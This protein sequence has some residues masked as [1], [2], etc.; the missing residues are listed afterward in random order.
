MHRMTVWV[1]GGMMVLALTV[2]VGISMTSAP[3]SGSSLFAQSGVASSTAMVADPKPAPQVDIEVTLDPPLSVQRNGDDAI[4][5]TVMMRTANLWPVTAQ[6]VR[7]IV[8]IPPEV[9]FVSSSIPGCTQEGDIV[10]CVF[11]TIAGNQTM[12]AALTYRLPAI[13]GSCVGQQI[14]FRAFGWNNQLDVDNG[15]NNALAT[16]TVGCP[17]T[18][19]ADLM[20]YKNGPTS[21]NRGGTVEYGIYVRNNGPATAE[22]VITTDIFPPGLTFL[23]A[24][25]D[26]RC[27]QIDNTVVCRINSLASGQNTTP[28]KIVY[29][30]AED[31]ACGPFALA[32]WV[33]G[34]LPDNDAT[35]DT[36]AHQ[37]TVNCASSSS[38]ASQGNFDVSVDLA[39]PTSINRGSTFTLIANVRNAGPYA[40]EGLE[41][42]LKNEWEDWRGLTFIPSQSD[43]RCTAVPSGELF[44]CDMTSLPVGGS[45]TLRL[46]FQSSQQLP[47]GSTRFVIDVDRTGDYDDFYLENNYAGIVV[48]VTCVSSSTPTS[49][50][51]APANS[52]DIEVLGS[53]SPVYV[54]G[55]GTAVFTF[56]ARNKGPGR[57][58]VQLDNFG[59]GGVSFDSLSD[60]RCQYVNGIVSCTLG[61]ID[62]GQEMSFSLTGRVTLPCGQSFS[63]DFS[64]KALPLDPYQ[65]NNSGGAYGSVVCGSSSAGMSNSSI[66][67]YTEWSMSSSRISSSTSSRPVAS[68]G[69]DLELTG[70]G[71]AAV[72]RGQ[73][74]THVLTMKNYGP[75]TAK[76]NAVYDPMGNGFT[77][78]PTDS[79]PRCAMEGGN[80]KCVPGDI[81]PGASETFVVSINTSA[82][83]TCNGV[84][85]INP[86]LYSYTP[87]PFSTNNR[88]RIDTKVV[89]GAVSAQSSVTIPPFSAGSSVSRQSS[90]ISMYTDW[91]MS[92][93]PVSSISSSTPSSASN[94]YDV[95]IRAVTAP[96]AVKGEPTTLDLVV[97]NAGPGTAYVMV[98]VIAPFGSI[99][100]LVPEQTDSRCARLEGSTATV[101]S[102]GYMTAGQE[103][104]ARLGMK[105]QLPCDQSIN[106]QVHSNS[107]PFDTNPQ[108]NRLL[109]P[110]KVIC[111]SSSRSSVNP[112]SVSPN[113]QV[114]MMITSNIMN[115]KV[116][117]GASIIHSFTVDNNGPDSASNVV[118]TEAIPSGFTY[119]DSESDPL[120]EQSGTSVRCPLGVVE[121]FSPVPV[122]I[123]LRPGDTYPCGI[124][125]NN[126]SVSASQQDRYA[127]SN[128][129]V[130]QTKVLCQSAARINVAV[131]ASED[132]PSAVKGQKNVLLTRFFVLGDRDRDITFNGARFKADVGSVANAASYSLFVDM[133]YNGTAE[134]GLKRGV[135]PSNG[136]VVFRDIPG[137]GQI[138]SAGRTMAMEVR[139]DIAFSPQSD[140]LQLGFDTAD[141]TYF[142]AQ[143]SDGSLTRTATN[144]NCP[145]EFCQINVTTATSRTVQIT[146]AGN[147]FVTK[148]AEPVRSKQLL[149]GMLGDTVM[150][151][152]FRS[153]NED[154]DVFHLQIATWDTTGVSLDRLE[155]Y[156]PGE[157]SPFAIATVGDCGSE[158]VLTTNPANGRS[159][160]TFC[161]NMSNRQLIVPTYAEMDVF[162]RPRLKT[163]ESGA[164][165]GEALTFWV[166]SRA[167]AV[168]ARGVTSTNQL[169]DNDN[170]NLGEGEVFI[171]VNT[172]ASGVHIVG[173]E[174]RS[175][176]SKIILIYNAITF[177]YPEVIAYEFQEIGRYRIGTTN[178]NNTKNGVN[179][180]VITDLLFSVTSS[181]IAF[182]PSTFRIAASSNYADRKN[183]SV[184]AGG[185]AGETLV[186]CRGLSFTVDPTLDVSLQVSITGGNSSSW[187]RSSL[188]NF[189]NVATSF[190]PGAGQGR[191]RWEDKDTAS[192]AFF[193][194]DQTEPS[195]SSPTYRYIQQ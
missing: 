31:F 152:N 156:K 81:A 115:A 84:Y 19:V 1:L 116:A 28:L 101:C 189:T 50:A 77:F 66:S 170:D 147:L 68:A 172:P 42:T 136:F 99:G 87:D 89:C 54:N 151:L 13:Q 82:T 162:V 180:P 194:V 135:T 74:F 53:V 153:P 22:D 192:T 64:T 191:I 69:A 16:T 169:T 108:N 173:N 14:Q 55:N 63:V 155:L 188:T 83:Q 119:V 113:G 141:P 96:T 56:T 174:N 26:G 72:S 130:A 79:D 32:T 27:D 24:Q 122:R 168:K 21:V 10:S 159:I 7:V 183:C 125:Q 128:T 20:M 92:S 154:V 80:V 150:R 48:P 195:A 106:V 90:S 134:T 40:T 25:S 123:A 117:Q 178:H 61:W 137:D 182:D 110:I 45:T 57:T 67:M 52:G 138:V 149:G 181:N 4:D 186:E 9:S 127:G 93:R 6:N 157:T 47:C 12:F 37:V 23:D 160:R 133:D 3:L 44:K 75:E 18:P 51:S 146:N 100:T 164:I 148:D 62:P 76:Y 145:H 8:P 109:A 142:I 126:V 176:L 187:I 60:S 39:G 120:C 78:N 167:G 86:A 177:P 43:P 59:Q 73:S 91:S 35:N 46:T 143:A 33:K 41:A 193:W 124:V 140:R 107:L 112:S 111:S 95:E 118:V 98:S 144:G 38:V 15:N 158:S 190:G 114:D 131:Q 71:P 171:G 166:P 129:V 49:F 29:Q 30:L 139:A 88:L 105:L 163:D 184:V 175:V 2:R 185:G 36:G 58:Y 161:A 104:T 94:L 34:S 103:T 121:P 179:K 165:S 102:L 97:R 65:P 11:P 70:T 5:M 85:G 132:M 17:A